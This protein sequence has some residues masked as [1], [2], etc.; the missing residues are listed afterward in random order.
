MNPAPQYRR[1][2]RRS[3]APFA[4]NWIGRQQPFGFAWDG[5]WAVSSAVAHSGKPSRMP[6]VMSSN[7]DA[8]SFPFVGRA[9]KSTST[10]RTCDEQH[11]RGYDS[12]ITH[13]GG[14]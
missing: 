14:C 3:A 5:A 9:L 7:A 13:K 2:S 11:R 12:M 4:I 6:E 10:G 8:R 1:M